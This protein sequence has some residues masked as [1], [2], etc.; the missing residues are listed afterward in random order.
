MTER[1]L[2]AFVASL[3]HEQIPN[4]VRDRGSHVIADTIA[5]MLGGASD[6]TVA[7]LTADWMANGRDGNATIFGTAGEQTTPYQAAFLNGT[8]GTVLELDEGHRFAKGHPAIHVLP[9]VLADGEGSFRSGEAL[10]TA[11]IAGYETAVRVARMITPLG[12]GYHPHGVWGGIGAAA[13][14]CRLRGE[15]DETTLEAI[16]IAAN[17][18]QHTRF[19]AATNGATVRNAYA[20]MSNLTGLIAADQAR[21]GFTGLNNGIRAHLERA[22]AESVDCHVLTDGL[23]DHWELERGYFK[24]HAACR[25]THAV[26]DALIELDTDHIIDPDTVKTIEVETYPAAAQ[27]T[28]T[29]PTNAL[30]AKFSIPFAVATALRMGETGK[31]AF[32]ESAITDATCDLA[33]CVH[34]SVADDI[35]ARTPDERGAR[36]EVTLESGKTLS[37]EVR[38]PRGGEHKPFTSDELHSKFVTLVTPVI[39]KERVE[40]LW[41]A[42]TE[43]VAPRVLC[44]LTRA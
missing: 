16:R 26:L 8:A 15:D 2:A 44:T 12:S 18:A 10:L 41:Q 1:A 3:T 27:L 24:I 6:P 37:A 4:R 14:V 11:F 29:H 36:I 21:A 9:A 43:P 19:E 33:E 39:G 23:G 42:A 17:Y 32:N 25:Y 30:Q 40:N 13:G 35:A 20:G 5:A 31:Q 22:A 7:R 38:A 28:S 34:V